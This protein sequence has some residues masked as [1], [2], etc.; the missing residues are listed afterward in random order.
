MTEGTLISVCTLTP[1]NT[2]SQLS[3]IWQVTENE[4]FAFEI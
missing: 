2:W 3:L 1:V 4:P